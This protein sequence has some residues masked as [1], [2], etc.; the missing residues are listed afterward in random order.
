[1]AIEIRSLRKKYIVAMIVVVAFG[2]LTG[3]FLGMYLGVTALK[4]KEDVRRQQELEECQNQ[5]SILA[6]EA[7]SLRTFS[8]DL[9]KGLYP[10]S[11]TRN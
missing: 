2:I 3:V 5:K 10:G 6:K 9:R 1:M 4:N 7:S 8:D 11:L